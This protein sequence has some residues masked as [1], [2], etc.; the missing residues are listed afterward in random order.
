MGGEPYSGLTLLRHGPSWL[1]L[2]ER[3]GGPFSKGA[4]AG[5]PRGMP[6]GNSVA[7]LDFCRP[8]LQA[9]RRACEGTLHGRFVPHRPTGVRLAVIDDRVQ[10]LWSVQDAAFP[11]PVPFQV[12]GQVDGS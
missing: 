2:A 6:P 4:A 11:Q 9:D 7:F 5:F 12:A 1:R 3:T 10:R 8:T